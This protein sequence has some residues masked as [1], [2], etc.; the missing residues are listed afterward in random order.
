MG[1]KPV[2]TKLREKRN[3]PP[4]GEPF[5][6]LSRELVCFGFWPD[7]ENTDHVEVVKKLKGGP[8]GMS[9]GYIVKSEG[10]A[11][12]HGSRVRAFTRRI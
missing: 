8:L 3:R 9:C 4:E 12:L 7:Y 5:V 11:L 10:V 6:W 2:H 1:S